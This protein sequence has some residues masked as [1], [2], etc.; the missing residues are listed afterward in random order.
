MHKN[1]GAT[2]PL[3]IVGKLKR[4]VLKVLATIGWKRRLSVSGA[5][6]VLDENIVG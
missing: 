1:M 3:K 4:Y 5:Y 2:G 6:Q